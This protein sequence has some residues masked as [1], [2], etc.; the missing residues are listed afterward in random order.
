LS[1]INYNYPPIYGTNPIDTFSLALELVKI[2]LQGFIARGYTISEANSCEAWKLEK[3]KS[4][5]E[6]IDELKCNKNISPE[7]K[8]KI[9]AI[10]KESFGK[11]T[12]MKEKFD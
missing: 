2:Y 1:D 7:Y 11:I 10:M 12:Q 8:D 3:G 5:S 9:L 4:L 6:R